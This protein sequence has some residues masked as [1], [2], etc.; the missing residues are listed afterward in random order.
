MPIHGL[1]TIVMT[2]HDI[3]SIATSLILGKADFAGKRCPDRIAC[4]KCYIRSI[5]HTSETASVTITR[6]NGSFHRM[7]ILTDI[8]ILMFGDH[9]IRSVWIDTLRCPEF[10][11]YLGI[12]S[13]ISLF[14]FFNLIKKQIVIFNFEWV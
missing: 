9:N 5:V 8:Y 4:M 11:I 10:C 2:H 14:A 3:I 13:Y 12:S 1:H 7:T 6:R